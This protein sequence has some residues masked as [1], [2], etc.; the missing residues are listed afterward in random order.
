MSEKTPAGPLHLQRFLTECTDVVAT[1]IRSSVG[2]H[3]S[4]VHSLFCSCIKPVSGAHLGSNGVQAAMNPDGEK[5]SVA[6]RTEEVRRR[7]IESSRNSIPAYNPN[8]GTSTVPD[9]RRS[10]CRFFSLK[11]NDEQGVV[12]AYCRRCERILLV[13]DRDLYWGVKRKTGMV[14]PTYRHVC[15]CGSHMFEV[16]IG[17]NY[18]DEALDENDID[19]ITVAVR[20]ASCNE[21][22]IVFD[23]EAT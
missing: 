22:A 3:V 5:A 13:Y 8:A 21:V 11:T 12:H 17:F 20:C 16:A 7:N 6:K 9:D 4:S 10:A 23:D 19:T 18:P 1:I 15:C 14:P 2:H